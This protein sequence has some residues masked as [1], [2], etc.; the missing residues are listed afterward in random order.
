MGMPTWTLEVVKGRVAGRSYVLG[1]PETILGNAL[2]G[3]PGIDL[4]DQEGDSPRRMAAQQAVVESTRNGLAVRDLDSPGGTFVNRQRILPG[5]AKPLQSGDVIQVGSVQLRVVP[6]NGKPAAATSPPPPPRPQAQTQQQPQASFLFTLK[7]GSVC[8]SCDDF[9]RVA[10]Q[11]WGDLRE[12]L[13]SGRLDAWLRSTG[14]ADLVLP[15]I[16]N[17]SPD[18]HLDAWLGRLPS[19]LPARPELDAHPARL[20]IKVTPGGGILTRSIQVANV[21]HRL[22][23]FRATIE[24]ANASWIKVAAPFAGQTHAVIDQVEVPLDVEIPATLPR[25]LIATLLLDGD[26]GSKRIE[27]VLEPKAAVDATPLAAGPAVAVGPSMAE[28]LSTVPAASRLLALGLGGVALRFAIAVASG[29]LGAGGMRASDAATPSLLGLA[30]VCG[31]V[32]AVVGGVRASRRGGIGE[33][34]FGAISAGIAGAA[35]AGVLVAICRSVEP[36][37]G[38][39]TTSPVLVALL[40]GVL[41]AVIAGISLL[42]FPARGKPAESAS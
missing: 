11:R 25:P 31:V 33:L 41:G 3:G 23:H 30:L 36:A 20:V 6:A 5:Q 8:R 24:P 42:V 16:V 21:G 12:E 9:L 37:L 27:L 18:E 4:A 14:R 39:W 28:R 17:A 40:W 26:G 7:S 10:A 35:L 38:G 22:L 1:G 34:G 29:S 13:S 19:T 32:A 15:R 2:N